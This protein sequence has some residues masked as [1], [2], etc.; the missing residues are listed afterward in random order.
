MGSGVDDSA[1]LVSIEEQTKT[2]TEAFEE[3]FPYYLSMGMTYDQFWRDDPEIV[4]YY[5]K[6][7]SLRNERENYN[8]W[9]QGSYIYNALL[10][11]SPILQAFAKKG[12]KPKPY[13]SEPY[14]IEKAKEEEQQFDSKNKG[15]QFMSKFASKHNEKRRKK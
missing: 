6:A 7:Q 14:K 13:L 3:A 10:C 4:K 11:V 2:Y 8:F 15:L 9:L 5:R 1:T 12:T